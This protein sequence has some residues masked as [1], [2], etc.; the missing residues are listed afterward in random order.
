MHIK[1][2]I[3]PTNAKKTTQRRQYEQNNKPT[4]HVS[5]WRVKDDNYDS[6]ANIF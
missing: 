6:N 5:D 1:R 4:K 3:F 2:D